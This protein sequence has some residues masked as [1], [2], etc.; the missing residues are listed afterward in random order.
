[1]AKK[2]ENK[3]KRVHLIVAEGEINSRKIKV[4]QWNLSLTKKK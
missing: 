4:N 3:R 1:M 2:Q